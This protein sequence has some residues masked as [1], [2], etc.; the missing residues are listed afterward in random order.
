MSENQYLEL[1]LSEFAKSGQRKIARTREK[2]LKMF[3][4]RELVTMTHPLGR[5]CTDDPG[6]IES[7]GPE[8]L[9]DRFQGDVIH[10]KEKILND[11]PIK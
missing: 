3:P 10:L 4:D 1:K 8:G 9:S 11:T 6:D 2:I 7:L 5:E